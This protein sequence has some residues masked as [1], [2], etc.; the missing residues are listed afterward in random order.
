MSMFDRYDNVPEGYIPNNRPRYVEPKKLTI[1]AGETAEHSFEVPFNTLEVC[2][3]VEIIYKLGLNPIII[4]KDTDFE[5]LITDWNT[6]II[7]NTLDVS[8]TL[9][10]ANTLLS[11]TVQLKFYMKDN[12]VTYSEVYPIVLSTALD[13]LES[14][15]TP[16]TPPTPGPG[17]I[18]G[19]GYTED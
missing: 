5:T 4:K 8:E 7:T 11:A 16:P 14:S 6:T 18:T 2:D 15:P 3:S 9:F 17:V 12:I 1:L 13:V 19:I 10:F